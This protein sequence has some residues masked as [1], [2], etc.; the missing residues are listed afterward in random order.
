[1]KK[2]PVLLSLTLAVPCSADITV[3]EYLAH[4]KTEER[5]I[6]GAYLNGVGQ[7]FSWA[8]F[9]MKEKGIPPMYCQPD[10]LPLDGSTYMHMVDR[11]IE[12]FRPLMEKR[13]ADNLTSSEGANRK[14]PLRVR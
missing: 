2:L 7:G 4:K 12:R 5:A 6:T 13:N 8:N 9:W 11:F 1:M 14:L 10:S 3:K